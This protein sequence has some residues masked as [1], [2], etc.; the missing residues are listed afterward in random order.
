LLVLNAF[1]DIFPGNRDVS[2]L[3]PYWIGQGMFAHGIM[4]GASTNEEKNRKLTDNTP[5]SIEH[6]TLLLNN[7]YQKV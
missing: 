5:E 1:S 4:T 6:T 2:V 7:S 3:L